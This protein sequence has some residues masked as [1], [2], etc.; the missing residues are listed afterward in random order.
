MPAGGV[1][2]KNAQQA[3][4][5]VEARFSL[6]VVDIRFPEISLRIEM[7]RTPCRCHWPRHN[8]AT[9]R[10]RGAGRPTTARTTTPAHRRPRA[11]RSMQRCSHAADRSRGALRLPSSFAFHAHARHAG[12]A[13][14]SYS[15]HRPALHI[16][17]AAHSFRAHDASPHYRDIAARQYFPSTDR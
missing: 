13:I 5:R 4:Q 10:T 9:S 6:V 14:S 3:H 12:D 1:T 8:G 2:A 17:T 11:R 7:P 15:P 16:Y